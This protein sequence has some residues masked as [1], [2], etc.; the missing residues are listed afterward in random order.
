MGYQK[1]EAGLKIKQYI[2]VSILRQSFPTLSRN[3]RFFEEMHQFLA[4][5]NFA[6]HNDADNEQGEV[7]QVSIT[8]TLKVFG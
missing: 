4:A 6:V 7:Q 2:P 5:M 1:G 3:D 8:Y